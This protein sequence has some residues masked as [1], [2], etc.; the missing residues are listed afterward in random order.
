MKI[1]IGITFQ[2]ESNNIIVKGGEVF[3]DFTEEELR[4]YDGLYVILE[5]QEEKENKNIKT[6]IKLNKA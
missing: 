5:K 2:R 6:K 4:K 1:Q 3:E